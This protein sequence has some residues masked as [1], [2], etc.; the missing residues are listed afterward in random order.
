MI[1]ELSEEHPEVKFVKIDVDEVGELAE[2]YGITSIPTV[3]IG[4]NN[5]IKEG[6]L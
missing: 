6:F 1:E 4:Y 2:E 5:E 3:F